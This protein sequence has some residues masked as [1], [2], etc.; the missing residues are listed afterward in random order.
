MGGRYSVQKDVGGVKGCRKVESI[1]VTFAWS[2][3]G[4]PRNTSSTQDLANG[5]HY[6]ATFIER[7]VLDASHKARAIHVHV[8]ASSP[9]LPLLA[10]RL[11]QAADQLLPATLSF[12]R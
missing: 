8:W 12:G 3:Q 2:E 9:Q 1:I 10:A 5:K 4:K 6:T 11:F 7:T